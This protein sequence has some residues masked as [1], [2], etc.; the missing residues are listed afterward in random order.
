MKAIFTAIFLFLCI[1]LTFSGCSDVANSKDVQVND[2]ET[3]SSS[4]KKSEYPPLAEKLAQAELTNLDN[5]TTTIADK[6]GKVV[7]VNMWATWCGPCRSEMPSLVRLQEA[8]GDKGL[9]VIG[10]NADEEPVDQI[11]K[12]A[13]DMKLNY[14]LVWADPETQNEFVKISKFPGIPQ[15][16]LIDRDG[17]L[18]GVFKGANPG[19]IRK[20]VEI[21]GKVVEE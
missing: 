18:R 16:F 15:S 21:V 3:N 4:A 6:K 12:F 10:L 20:M 14:T 1:A 5:S 13:G 17:N 9:E 19:D 7:L 8:Y 11:N 2:S